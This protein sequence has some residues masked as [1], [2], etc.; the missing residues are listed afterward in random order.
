MSATKPA[1]VAL[2]RVA[3]IFPSNVDKHSVDGEPDVRLCNY[4]DVY[5]NERI[6]AD[7]DFTAATASESQVGRFTLR[8]DDVLITK[9]SEEPTDIGIPAYVP[10]DLPGVV[11]GYHLAVLRSRPEKISGRYLHWALQGAEVHAYYSTAATGISRCALS[12]ND[13]GMTPLPLPTLAEQERIANFL[14]EKTARID[15]LIA[16]KENLLACLTE[17][18]R[19]QINSFV[20][21]NSYGGRGRLEAGSV[22]A[23]QLPTDWQFVQLA[24]VVTKLTNGFVGPTRDILVTDG[25]KYLQSLHIKG[26]RID[27]GRGEYYVRQEWSDAHLK[28]VLQEND[29]LIVQTGD[30]GQTALVPREYVGCN[31]HALIIATPNQQRVIPA[32]LELVL[33]SAYGRACFYLYS[34][35]ALHPHLNCSNIRDIRIP[36][37]PLSCQQDIVNRAA[38]VDAS[39]RALREHV[40]QH[41]AHLREYRASLI[42]A[43][44]TGQLCIEAYEEAA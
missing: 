19:A 41:M 35:G 6:T 39:H 21:G 1:R 14:D 29:I 28:S 15:E 26:G 24:R 38:V 3:S 12:V 11:C 36:L 22:T 40:E 27:F 8:A 7:L 13:V 5:K 10:K 30:I 2:K 32:F 25:V 23:P 16:E 42:S 33:R 43:A 18:E 4:V 17:S 9:D 34:T 20:D 44:V 31:C 37:P